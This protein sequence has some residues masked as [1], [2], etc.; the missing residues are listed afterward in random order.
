M[1]TLKVLKNILTES[2]KFGDGFSREMALTHRVCPYVETQA[3]TQVSAHVLSAVLWSLM[4]SS[5]SWI[6]SLL[7]EMK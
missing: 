2:V 1:K 7:S 3:G 4:H 6:L 5:P